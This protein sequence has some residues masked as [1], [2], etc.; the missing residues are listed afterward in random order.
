MEADK[1]LQGKG[2]F[3]DMNSP[4]LQQNMK[5]KYPKVNTCELQFSLQ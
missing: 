4:M 3:H 5:T 2:H 1:V